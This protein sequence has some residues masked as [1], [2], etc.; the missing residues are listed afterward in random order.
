MK[1]IVIGAGRGARLGRLTDEQPKCMLPIGGVPIL[2]RAVEALLA[3]GIEDVVVIRGYAAELLSCPACR[4]VEHPDWSGTNVLGSLF[5]ADDEIRGDV[6]IVYSD[7][8]FTASIVREAMSTAGRI[9]PVV[10]RAWLS[11]YVGRNDH[12]P[13]EAEKV[14]LEAGRIRSIGK[15]NVPAEA[16]DG[17][18]IGMLKLDA[19]GASSI[20]QAY[21]RAKA[22]FAGRPF[23][24][25]QTFESAY[26]T[27]LLQFMVDGG[28][29]ICPA[30]IEGGWREI[31]TAE[32]LERAGAWLNAQL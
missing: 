15:M 1:A 31:D 20:R 11:A 16:A 25:A 18:F 5:A 24:T 17:E 28:E 27:D 19:A 9:V 7:I 14:S 21:A 2:H 8:L 3:S 23:A 4:Y 26:L 30:I 12:P 29:T 6:L 32:D 13:S 10:D 22:R